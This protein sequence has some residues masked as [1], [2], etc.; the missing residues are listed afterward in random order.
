MAFARCLP[1]SVL[2]KDR[3]RLSGT[4]SGLSH[5][6][7]TQPIW[8]VT[9]RTLRFLSAKIA[10]IRALVSKGAGKSPRPSRSVADMSAR[11]LTDLRL[12]ARLANPILVCRLLHKVQSI[13]N[14]H[15]SDRSRNPPCVAAG[16]TENADSES[17]LGYPDRRRRLPTA[18][19]GSGP[20]AQ[21]GLAGRSARDHRASF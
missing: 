19:Y 14:D 21:A 1:S 11:Q 2:A 18:Q 8:F 16:S 13:P 3:Q 10:H 15:G 12:G 9:I 7:S 17:Y 6:C 4:R 20:A 5:V